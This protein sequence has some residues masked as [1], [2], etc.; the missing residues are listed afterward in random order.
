MVNTL[1]K[2][3]DKDVPAIVDSNG[4]VSNGGL[5][6]SVPTSAPASAALQTS[7]PVEERNRAVT[8]PLKVRFVELFVFFTGKVMADFF[9]FVVGNK[10][11]MITDSVHF[12]LS[13]LYLTAQ[14]H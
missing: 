7:A 13:V 12:N 6:G 4:S 11:C 5:P 10:V 8:A 3:K 14:K 9:V 1:R 2:K